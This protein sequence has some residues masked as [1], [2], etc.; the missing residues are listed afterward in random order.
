M[1]IIFLLIFRHCTYNDLYPRLR[2]SR[3]YQ[4]C[5]LFLSRLEKCDR[6]CDRQCY[7]QFDRQFNSISRGQP[8]SEESE[9]LAVRWLE[10]HWLHRSC[11]VRTAERRGKSRERRRSEEICETTSERLCPPVV[12]PDLPVRGLRQLHLLLHHVVPRV[13]RSR[14]L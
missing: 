11:L 10:L 4:I 1:I 7:R 8:R 14:R 13:P 3:D 12:R 2:S 9:A 5:E 6:Q